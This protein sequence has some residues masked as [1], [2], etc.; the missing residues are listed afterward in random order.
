MGRIYLLALVLNT[1]IALFNFLLVP[2]YIIPYYSKAL[3]FLNH[4]CSCRGRKVGLAGPGWHYSKNASLLTQ[5][6]LLVAIA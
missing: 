3:A 5:E 1:H 4:C 6:H 2:H